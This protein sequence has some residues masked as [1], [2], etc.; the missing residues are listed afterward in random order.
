MPSR[1]SKPSRLR[2]VIAAVTVLCLA[3]TACG[4][5]QSPD[6]L[7]EKAL[8][9]QTGDIVIGV[10]W[11]FDKYRDQFREG[12]NLALEQI[13]EKGVLGGKR[14]RL[15]EQDD[16]DSVIRGLEIAQQFAEDLS[17]SAVIGHRSSAVTVPAS[18]I[19]DTAGI[20]L[21]TPSSTSPNLTN[22]NSSFVFRNI[23]SDVHIGK[24]M[25]EYALD[26]GYRRIAIYY[27]EDE[28]GRGLANSFEDAANTYGLTIIDR[29]SGYKDSGDV[30]RIANKWKTLDCDLVLVA[31]D[32]GPGLDFIRELRAA[33]FD[34]PVVGG[35]TLDSAEMAAAGNI[36][37]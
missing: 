22:Q 1:L 2:L 32:V 25:A 33:G 26:Y 29:L 11:P 3:L 37:E 34:L 30:R 36:T 17:V 20:L 10:V 8:G 28:Y 12:L 23:P 31:A 19:Y 24:E 6:E 18:R 9:A 5:E 21:M 4:R 15:I 13:N 27:T 14:I 35:D 7:R 16:G